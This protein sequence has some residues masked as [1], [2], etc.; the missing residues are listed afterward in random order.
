MIGAAQQRLVDFALQGVV[1]SSEAC[2]FAWQFLG[3][4]QLNRDREVVSLE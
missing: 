3:V 1:L 2:D 4:E